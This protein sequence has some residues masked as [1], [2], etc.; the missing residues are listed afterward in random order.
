MRRAL[1]AALLIA[2]VFGFATLTVR[3]TKSLPGGRSI[4]VEAAEILEGDRAEEAIAFS[5]FR[6]RWHF[7]ATIIVFLVIVVV[8]LTGGAARI[9][10]ASQRFGESIAARGPVVAGLTAF[11]GAGLLM[12]VT[13][14]TQSPLSGGGLAVALAF[15]VV[16]IGAGMSRSFGATATF[17]ALFS[18][19]LTLVTFPLA[20]YRGFVIEHFY[21]QSNQSLA[22]WLAESLRSEIVILLVWVVLI[23]AAY[24]VISRRP[25]DW[26]I[27]LSAA[28][29]P[30]LV[31]SLLIIP[32]YV[33]PLF[34]RFRPLRDADLRDRILELADRAGIEDGRV[35]E[36]DKSAQTKALNAYVTGLFGTKRIVLWDTLLNNM[37][38]D[39]V[40]F[41]MAHEMGHYVENHIWWL[42]VIGTAT[43]TL[44]LFVIHRVGPWAARRFGGGRIDDI[45]SLPILLLLFGIAFF[46]A[47]P[48]TSGASRIIER[49]ADVF[50]LEL[51]QDSEAAV[52]AYVALANQN[53][54]DPSPPRFAEFWLF[55]HPTLSDRIEM[56]RKYARPAPR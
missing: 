3:P 12:L 48:A 20:Y 11:L 55:T 35:F 45:A 33:D 17:T 2:L 15:G 6:Y 34:N 37:K 9:R 24:W 38:D 7:F 4:P 30:L 49:R 19:T 28:I 56:A 29:P 50:A 36:V 25:K 27:W 43:G 32:I 51:T 22:E 54:S 5:N 21:G 52:G 53:L 8:L 31:A 1:L 10:R 26:W 46:L 41:V 13:S 42:V 14:N 44:I 18:G 16:G 40:A 47:E 23:P 39:E